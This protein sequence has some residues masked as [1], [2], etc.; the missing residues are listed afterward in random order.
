MS[1]RKMA[2][3]QR[4]WLRVF[5]QL[6][7]MDPKDLL[8]FGLEIAKAVVICGNAATRNILV[9]DFQRADGVIGIVPVRDFLRFVTSA[10]L[11]VY[12]LGPSTTTTS[13]SSI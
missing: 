1:L 4:L 7:T 12:S 6:P 8:P 13:R 3:F 11:Y 10:E 5:A 9:F 2:W